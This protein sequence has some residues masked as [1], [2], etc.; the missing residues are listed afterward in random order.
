MKRFIFLSILL[1]AFLVSNGQNDKLPDYKSVFDSELKG[2]AKTI[3]NFS[4]SSFRQTAVVSFD[5]LSY[6]DVTDL[7]EFYSIYK[8]A[9]SFSPDKTQFLDLYSYWLNLEKEDNKII[10][11]GSDVDQ[12]I[13]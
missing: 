13:S 8:P 7:E 12:L 1:P 11:R 4:L 10:W 3:S 2:W 6:M 5:T 9:L